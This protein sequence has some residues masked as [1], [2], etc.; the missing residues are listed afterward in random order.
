MYQSHPDQCL[1]HQKA[2]YLAVLVD[3]RDDRR[4]VFV[5]QVG[6]KFAGKYF[7]KLFPSF[8]LQRSYHPNSGSIGLLCSTKPPAINI[9]PSTV[10]SP[11][12][13]SP[14][15]TSI[16]TIRDMKG[17]SPVCLSV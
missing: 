14:C 16:E 6:I 10:G 5:R 12:V 4:S 9:P 17:I 8:V 1:S 3:V 15:S 11:T 7:A 2:L 13:K